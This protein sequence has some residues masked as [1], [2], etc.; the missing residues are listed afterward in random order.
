MA[1]ASSKSDNFRNK[2]LLLIHGS[3]D[4]TSSTDHSHD[5]D[6]MMT[7]TAVMMV[8]MMRRSLI[9]TYAVFSLSAFP[10]ID[11]CLLS[12]YVCLCMFVYVCVP[13]Y[14]CLCMCAYVCV[15]MYMCLCICV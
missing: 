14:V 12:M 15:S 10:S 9:T 6:M 11:V 3:A 4:G 7:T 1:N 5:D 13:M 8:V 2:S